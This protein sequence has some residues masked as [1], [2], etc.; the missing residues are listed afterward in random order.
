[1]TLDYDA[2]IIIGH[3]NMM[4]K[5]EVDELGLTGNISI[6]DFYLLVNKLMYVFQA[7]NFYNF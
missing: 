2:H 1:M 5:K 6:N 7:L 4:A 3:I